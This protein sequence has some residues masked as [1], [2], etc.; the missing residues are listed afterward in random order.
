MA[1][2]VLVQGS[3]LMPSALP[4]END[5]LPFIRKSRTSCAF[6]GAYNRFRMRKALEKSDLI[7]SRRIFGVKAVRQSHKPE[8]DFQARGTRLEASGEDFRSKYISFL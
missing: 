6:R 2:E 3:V 5:N 8:I 1:N 4:R 7:L